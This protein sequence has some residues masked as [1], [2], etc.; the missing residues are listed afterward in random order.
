MHFAK[1]KNLD[2]KVYILYDTIHMTLCQRQNYKNGKY[3]RGCRGW[4][5]R[6]LTTKRSSQGDETVVSGTQVVDTRFSDGG[7]S[8]SRLER[9]VMRDK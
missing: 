1:S 4:G 5:I 7:A 3:I 6:W 8:V 9:E 2:P